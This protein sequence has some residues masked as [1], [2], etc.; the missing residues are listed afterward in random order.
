MQKGNIWVVDDDSSIRWVL[1]RAITREGLTCKTFE[2]A[3]DVLSALNS[4]LPDVLLSDI[5]MPDI[6]GL[7]LLKSVKEQHPTLPVIIMTAHS[8]LDAAVNAYQQGAFDYL[9]SLLILMIHLHSFIVLLRTIESKN[10][11][12]QQKLTFNLSLT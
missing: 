10:N 8:D 11:L 3:N 2:H 5:R 12:I 7:S 9:P 6:D 4:E 1:E